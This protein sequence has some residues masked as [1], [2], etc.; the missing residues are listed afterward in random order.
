MRFARALDKSQFEIDP[1]AQYT[2]NV[3]PPLLITAL[4][5]FLYGLYIWLFRLGTQALRH[6]KQRGNES[7]TNRFF[8]LCLIGLFVLATVSVPVS[9]S[10]DI[11]QVTVS[12]WRLLE[13]DGL[14]T[15]G[16]AQNCLQIIRIVILW[17]MSITVDTILVYRCYVIYNW[18]KKRYAIALAACCV[19][20][21]I[22][23]AI[24]AIGFLSFDLSAGYG[25]VQT[26]DPAFLIFRTM[27]VVFA[28]AHIVLNF[29]LTSMIASRIVWMSWM[30]RRG[31][32]SR[33]N[34]RFHTVAALLLE[35]GFLYLVA[36]A[37][38][39]GLGNISDDPYMVVDTTS[40]WIQVAGI[41]PTLLIVRANNETVDSSNVELSS[42]SRSRTDSQVL[43][44]FI[45]AS[46]RGEDIS[47]TDDSMGLGRRSSES[48]A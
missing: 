25:N 30:V 21:D 27:A 10:W 17:F 34:E 5:L 13:L 22:V 23:A 20:I 40:I 7:K 11:L 2:H 19:T 41:A 8:Y 6:R 32:G 14:E 46:R 18:S 45:A 44:T 43:S 39:A 36:G 12:Y 28:A 33:R 9:L 47:Q 16:L 29:I 4:H 1:I 26:N 31:M 48:K 24:F 3:L 42:P 38:F 37:I 15:I 35:S